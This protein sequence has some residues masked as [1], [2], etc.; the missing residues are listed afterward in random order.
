M[1]GKKLAIVIGKPGAGKGTVLGRLTNEHKSVEVI[2]PGNMLRKAITAGDEIALKAKPYMDRGELVPDEIMLKFVEGRI[3]KAVADIVILD[4]FP[5]T[6]DQFIGIVEL[7]LK[8][9]ILVS[10][11]VTDDEVIK[12]TSVRLVCEKCGESYSSTPD[13]KPPKQEGICDTCGGE[14]QKRKDDDVNVVKTRLQIYRQMFDSIIRTALIHKVDTF[15]VDS[16]NM[17]FAYKRLVE[18]LS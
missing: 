14:L 3:K 17:E 7:G 1:N 4:G 16:T 15:S 11:D 8:P 18:V 6:T 2:S 10:L 13:L 5:R 9:D 12:R